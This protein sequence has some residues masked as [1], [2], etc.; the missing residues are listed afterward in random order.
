MVCQELKYIQQ[1]ANVLGL[2]N[3][4]AS[5]TAVSILVHGSDL[6]EEISGAW[7]A[8]ARQD[9]RTAGS[10]FQKAVFGLYQWT[11][12][13]LCTSDVCYVFSGVLQYLSDL[14]K[15][16][17]KCDADLKDMMGEFI[18]ASKQLTSHKN[19]NGLK[20]F[21]RN[22]TAIEAG[23]GDIGKGIEDLANSV[24][25]CHLKE[26]AEILAALA[27]KLHIAPEV[28][29]VEEV[30]K[31]VIDGVTIEREIAAALEDFGEKNWPGFGYNLIKLVKTLLVS[32]A[33]SQSTIVI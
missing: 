23:I 13:H 1:E 18:A 30:L 5:G 4:T 16:V 9:Y 10:E 22:I 15:D 29:V 31:I 12:G 27:Q 25:D 6:A 24:G 8:F 14:A 7:A 11:T 17:K 20:G 33:G 21:T 32:K 19:S 3:I 28:A 2:G 26:L